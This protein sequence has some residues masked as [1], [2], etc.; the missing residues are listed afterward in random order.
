MPETHSSFNRGVV[1]PVECLSSGFALIKGQY[2]LILGITVVGILIGAL[3]PMGIIM[4]PMMCGIY[5]VL[6]ERMAGRNVR[7]ELLFKGFDYFL[8]SL[9]ATLLLF[10]AMIVLLLPL[11]A[12]MIVAFFL[13]Q[14]RHAAGANPP[15]PGVSAA[16][17]VGAAL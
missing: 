4:G 17:I 11:Y 12:F 9:I 6:F 8:Q 5:L 2:W 14:H 3:V 1:R 15:P 7:F 13:F 16:F 10:A